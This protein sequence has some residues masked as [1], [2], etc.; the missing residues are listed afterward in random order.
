MLNFGYFLPSFLPSF[1]PSLPFFLP[2]FFLFLSFSFFSH[3]AA[4]G[5]PS[6][7]IRS[8]SHIATYPAAA[9]TLAPLTHRARPEIEPV[10]W[11]YRDTAEDPIAP[12]WE[13]Q[14]FGSLTGQKMERRQLN[15][16]PFTAPVRDALCGCLCPASPE[17]PA[18]GE[19]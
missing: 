2:S 13:L 19:V 9:A 5:A 12:Q 8:K 14:D 10:S 1:P 18:H 6:P 11:C 17:V 16:G 7:G 4:H 3:P 15:P